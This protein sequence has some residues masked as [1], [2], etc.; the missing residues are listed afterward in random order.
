MRGENAIRR[1]SDAD[2]R[3]LWNRDGGYGDAKLDWDGA[4]C[5]EARCPNR[6]PL[7]TPRHWQEP[8]RRGRS[9]QTAG[10]CE[11][12]RTWQSRDVLCRTREWRPWRFCCGGDSGVHCLS[13]CPRLDSKFEHSTSA[14]KR[15]CTVGQVLKTFRNASFARLAMGP[16]VVNVVV[17]IQRHARQEPAGSRRYKTE[18]EI[19]KDK[20]A[21]GAT[22]C[23]RSLRGGAPGGCSSNGGA[24]VES[25]ARALRKNSAGAADF[26]DGVGGK[27]SNGKQRSREQ[28]TFCG[29]CQRND[30]L[31]GDDGGSD[32]DRR[33]NRISIGG[34]RG[35]YRCR[36]CSCRSGG[37]RKWR[38]VRT[39]G[40]FGVHNFLRADGAGR[41]KNRCC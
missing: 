28:R 32:G 41:E 10:S 16:N 4:P 39:I 31:I 17:E 37:L 38:D 25:R 33:G 36:D 22:W 5:G 8:R 15:T 7:R 34:G 24:T 14:T 1:I 21:P 29:Y 35:W 27:Q 30:S 6:I 23:S 26:R 20:K 12:F 9:A 19:E 18:K 11:R 13:S 3:R 2:R 40:E